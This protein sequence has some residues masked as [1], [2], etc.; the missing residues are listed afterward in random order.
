MKRDT[1]IVGSVDKQTGAFSAT[2][3]PREHGSA[4]EANNEAQRL[5]GINPN[6]KFAVLRVLG[7]V[8]QNNIVWE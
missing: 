8:S 4:V 6:K 3:F 5:A 7:I 2:Q 1:F